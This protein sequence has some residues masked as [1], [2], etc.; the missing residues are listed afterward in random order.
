MTTATARITTSPLERL[1]ADIVALATQLAAGTAEFLRLVGEY[2]AAEGWRSW[3]LRSTAEW[4][5]WQCGVG[6]N[7]AREQVRV[8]RALR[9]LP[10]LAAAFA[11]GRLSYSKVRA[12]TRTATP[13]TEG[14]LTEWAQHATAAQIEQLIGAQRRAVRREDAAAR[15]AA[16]YLQW[17][18]DDDGSVVGS[19]RLTPEDAAIVLSALE[20]AQ[21]VSAE[22][23]A[24]GAKPV[25]E[26]APAPDAAPVSAETQ[27]EADADVSAETVSA[28]T[29]AMPSAGPPQR[30]A[31]ALVSVASRFLAD[32]GGPRMDAEVGPPVELLVHMPAEALR[33]QDPSLDDG[34][35][36]TI[37]IAPG[38]PRL[39][40]HPMSARRLVCGCPVSVVID[41]AEGNPLHLGRRTRRI[42]G[43][44]ARAVHRRDGGRCQAPGCTR[45][46]TQIHHI[47][48]W[49]DGGPTCLPNLLSLCDAHHWLVHDGGWRIHPERDRQGRPVFLRP[50][51]LPMT[52]VPESATVTAVPSRF[53]PP[54]PDAVAGHWDG[55]RIDRDAALRLLLAGSPAT[56]H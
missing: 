32:P 22:T 10:T 46:T 3:G 18:V 43:R 37:S 40:L 34:E 55:S 29:Q 24:S 36:V 30:R 4:L 26:A 33:R 12:I 56:A 8:A 38:V 52:A 41:D 48:H 17:R 2:D 42:T 27:P 47:V 20:T 44:L 15:H 51:R 39:R 28:E 16:R 9:T 49:A 7:A 25:I 21:R 53:A 23:P 14:M 6:P 5:S 1:E 13:E 45:R 35:A 11:A 19:F 31:D 50:D 54:R